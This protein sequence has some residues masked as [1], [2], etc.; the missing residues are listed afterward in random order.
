MEDTKKAISVAPAEDGQ[1]VINIEVNPERFTV[2]KYKLIKPIE[3][4]DKKYDELTLDFGK[5]TG[6]DAIKIETEM[7]MMNIY[8]MA[9]ETSRS[10]QI[11]MAAIAGGFPYQLAEKMSFRDFNRVANAA[12]NFLVGQEL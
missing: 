12:R 3:Y 9:P 7:E 5:L 8:V 1:T 11:R 10:Y 4:E 6:N 2:F